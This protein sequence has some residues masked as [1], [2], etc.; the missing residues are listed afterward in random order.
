M[1]RATHDTATATV[2]AR[3]GAV[4]APATDEP[5]MVA[6]NTRLMQDGAEVSIR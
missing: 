1:E 4:D 6:A 3:R 5:G 2:S